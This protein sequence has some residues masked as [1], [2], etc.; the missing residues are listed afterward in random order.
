M[1]LNAALSTDLLKE[2]RNKEQ[3]V[4]RP[5]YLSYDIA[6][7]LVCDAWKA[8]VKGIPAGCFLLAFYDG[9]D[10]VEEAVLLR[11]LSQTKLPTD[12]D[13]ISSMIEYYKD[14]LDISG[15]AGSLKGGKLDEFTR[16]EF[17]FSGLECRVLGVF[18]RTQKGN[19]EFGADL[20]NFY[21]ANNYTVYK[22]NRD[23]LEF[24]VNQRDDGGLVGQD[25]EFKIGSVRYSSSRRHQS[26]EENVNVWVNP[27]DFLGKRSAMFGMTRT[28]KSNTVK[29]VIEATEEISR[30][31]LI[32]LDSAS[33]E[34][35]EFTS[36]GSPTFPVGQII[37]DVNGEYANANRQDSGTAIYDLYKEKVYRYS[38]LEKD[39]FKVMKVNFFKDIES[40]FSL[41][42]SYF[43]EQSLGG[44]YVNNFI[45]VSFEKPESTN[46]N[47]SEWTRYN[48][49]IAAYKCCLYRAGFKAPN[50]EKIRFTG[51]AEINGEILEGRV[52]DPKQGLTL[53]EACTWFERVWEQYDELKFFKDYINKKG[54]EWANDD[55]KSMMVFLT[56]YKLPGKKNQVSGY[57]KI[58]VKQLHNLHTTS[59]D[60]SFEIEIPRLLQQGKIVIVDLSQG[61]PVVQRLFSEKICRSTFNISMDRFINNLPNNFIQFYFEEAHNLF[62]KKDDKDL[63]QI[64]NRIAKEGAKLHLGMIYATQEVSSISSNILKNTQNWF[65]AH[66]NN[67]DETKELEKYYDFKDFTH[68]LVNFSATNDKG[69]VRMKTYTNPFIVPVQIDRFLANKGM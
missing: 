61:E 28:G 34:T 4:G 13:V 21:A 15:R 43:Q 54:Y 31:A 53:E 17:S 37:F 42:S 33:P 57:K 18:Y 49:L 8:Q 3:F 22:A 60:E 2:G 35:S 5:F 19:I 59:M 40:G 55:L 7:L 41:I 58:R 68:S 65:I 20:E 48:R 11:A 66:L 36:S 1:N 52:L 6:R 25:S 16:Y 46:L 24:I 29:K 26:Q 63:S 30:K 27:K 51:A 56:T 44:D 69:F 12:N 62:P 32:L 45:A 67:I 47:G 39:D 23:V 14:N 64:Y 38:V 10:G 9:E 50:G